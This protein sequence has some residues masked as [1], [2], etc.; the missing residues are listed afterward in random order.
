MTRGRSAVPCIVLA[1]TGAS[2]LALQV[3]WQRVVSL[4][5]GS[6]VVTNSVVVAGF[7]C[8]L[9]L[10]SLIGG[11]LSTR[12]TGSAA[13]RVVAVAELGVAAF[14][15]ISTW[16]LH[17]LFFSIR[18]QMVGTAGGAVLTVVLIVVPATG[19]GVSL[20]LVSAV[21]TAGVDRAGKVVGRLYACNTAGAAVGAVA[22]GW[23]FVGRYGYVRSTWIAA[24]LGV[25]AA[26]LL[27]ALAAG[28]AERDAVAG[29]DRGAGDRTRA[30]AGVDDRSARPACEGAGVRRWYLVYAASGAAAVGLQQIAFRVA[31]AIGRSNSYSFAT[32]LAL[33]LVAFAAGLAAGSWLVGRVADARRGFF[34]CQF[35]AGV[36]MLASI[37]VLTVVMPAAGWSTPL[38]E[39]F[40]GDG[41]ADGYSDPS[42]AVSD[43]AVF[44]VLLPALV[45]MPAVL[46]MG[47]SFA[48]V[49]QVVVGRLRSVG[50][51]TGGLVAANTFGNVVGAAAAALILFDAFGTAGSAVVVAVALVV[52][53]GLAASWLASSWPRRA[54]AASGVVLMAV[55]LALM[56]PDNGQLWRFLS[57]DDRPGVEVHLAETAAC[58]SMVSSEDGRQHR[59]TINA[60]SQN[61]HPFDD[62]HVLIGLVPALMRDDPTDALSVGYGIGST[63]Y[64]LLADDGTRSVDT[65][66][67]CGG[68]YDVSDALADRGVAEFE[69]LRDDPR[70]ER[71]VGDGRRHILDSD[72]RYDVVVVDTMR[73]T[74]A[75]SGQH[76]SREFYEMALDAL[77]PD[78][79]FVQWVPTWRTQNSAAQVFPHLVTASVEEYGGSTFMIGSRQPIDVT[80]QQ[81]LQRFQDR[82]AAAFDAEQRSRLETFLAGWAPT[83]VT[84][85]RPASDV[86]AEWSNSDLFPRDEYHR[87]NGF[88]SAEQTI[89]SCG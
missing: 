89:T 4:H 5:L 20:P 41:F 23:V 86:P 25:V 31:S 69:R 74:S 67:I 2:A 40:S 42:F 43:I 65:V 17:G 56:T 47:A 49:E 68:H 14:A 29:P 87:E 15:V 85:G 30:V 73:V 39:W 71:I 60:T 7:L 22:A 55:T 54:L 1:L 12:L 62:F 70:H 52:A 77:R 32:V 64:G 24:G 75:T 21:A 53:A 48:F 83:C 61:D 44:A 8:G 51:G 46:L 72:A 3:V 6:D 35:G 33:Y 66:E 19:M 38:S 26:C 11:R 80:P 37:V 57:G 16:V 63:S 58:A 79:V 82:A 10:G 50:R 59:L 45:V 34:W 78:G 13:L 76:F 36:A 81:L 27:L 88:I 84:A 18:P 28:D 9:G